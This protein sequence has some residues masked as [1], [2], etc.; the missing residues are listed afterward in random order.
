[1]LRTTIFALAALVPGVASALAVTATTPASNA[2]NVARNASITITFDAPVDLASV[3]PQRL[4]VW[5]RSRGPVAA[6]QSWSDGNRTVTLVPATTF[7]PGEWVSV[8]L[9]SGI[10]GTDA[11]TLRAGGYTLQYVTRAGTGPM[12]FTKIDE[13]TVRTGSSVTVLYGGQYTDLN[14][15]GFIDYATVNEVSADVRVLLNRADGTGLFHPVLQPPAPIGQVASPSVV[16]DFNRDGRMDMATSNTDSGTVSVLLGNGNGTFQPQQSVAMGVYNH[17]IAALDVDGDGDIDLATANQGSNNVSITL[18][19][20]NGVFGLATSFDSGANQEYGLAAGDMDEDGLVDLVIGARGDNEIRVLRSNG[21]GTFSPGGPATHVAA[22]GLS[23]K[24]VLGDVN[25]DG[26]LDVTSAN[27]QSNNAGVVLGNGDGT[28]Q[29]AVV[30]PLNGQIVG[31]ELGDLDGDGD[32]DWMVSSFG[33]SRW[34]VFEND[35]TGTF[36]QLYD[37]PSPRNASCAS[38]FDFDNDGDLDMA[39]ADENA[40]V[41]LLMRNEPPVVFRN[42]FED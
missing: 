23:W 17:G 22:G 15:D 3:T 34:Y 20:G 7:F 16:A 5:G 33:G 2:T 12:T 1:M 21:D 28:L 27:S 10:A 39:L 8:Q 19:D 38:A 35:G 11:S 40:D 29:P 4:F 41:V 30:Y 26:H 37:I 42:G 14:R 6:T 31:T 18:N 32:L 36:T 24:I 25:G 9:A 13:V